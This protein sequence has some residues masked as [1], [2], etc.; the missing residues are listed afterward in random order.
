VNEEQIE[1]FN[2]PPIPKRPHNK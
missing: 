1:Q 2:L